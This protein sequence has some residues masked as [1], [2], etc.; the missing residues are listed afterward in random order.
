MK[1]YLKIFQKNVREK[2]SVLIEAESVIGTI[3]HNLKTLMQLSQLK[4]Q[5]LHILGIQSSDKELDSAK[6]S[7]D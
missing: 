5:S 3:K 6:I 1:T 2:I 7:W 4:S